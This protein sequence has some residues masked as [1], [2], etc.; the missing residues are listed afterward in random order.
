MTKIMV[1]GCGRMGREII[2][3]AV[4]SGYRLVAAIDAEDSPLNGADAG[5]ISGINKLGV[6]VMPAT[7]LEQLLDETRPD[8]VVDFTNAQACFWNTKVIVQKNTN[9]VIGTTGLTPGQLKEVEQEIN[10]H[11]VGAVISPNMSVGVNVFWQLIKQATG[12]LKDY[13]I[14]LIESH[15]RF[16]KDAPSGTAIKTADIISEIKG[17]KLEDVGVYG[18]HGAA[19]RKKDEIGIHAIRAGDIVGE[20]TVIYATLGERIEVTHKAHSRGALVKGVIKAI[21]FIKD[22]KGVYGMDEVLG[23]N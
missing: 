14:E 20:H 3:E 2:R 4:D 9:M 11:N 6:K 8:V 1:L 16:K 18:R 19:E 13:D 22:K 15:H 7:H 12:Y 17:D 10:N 21:K 5:L 23:L